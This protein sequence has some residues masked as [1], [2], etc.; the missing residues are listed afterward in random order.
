MIEKVKGPAGLFHFLFDLPAFTPFFA[1]QT[2]LRLFHFHLDRF[3]YS[4]VRCC[5]FSDRR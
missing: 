1:A 2:M 4:S 3:R 5:V